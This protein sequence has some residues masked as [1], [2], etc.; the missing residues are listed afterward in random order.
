[1]KQIFGL[2]GTSN[3]GKS[4]TIKNVYRKLTELYP[5]FIFHKDFKFI[6]GKGDIC[7]IIIINGKIIGIESQ[8]D[9][10]SRIFINLPI[11][12][13]F[14]CDIIL[15]ATRT[16]GATVDEVEK[17]KNTYEVK[18][19]KKNPSGNAIKFKIDNDKLA[20]EILNLIS[21]KIQ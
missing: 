20:G 15:C 1:M 18:W 19:I 7:V 10:N 4:E 11:F 3:V 8:G 9:P 13:K 6:V 14:N 16:R 5:D 17:L 12:V 2:Y 21:D